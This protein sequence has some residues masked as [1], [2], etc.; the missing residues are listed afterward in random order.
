MSLLVSQ[1]ED[2]IKQVSRFRT[3]CIRIEEQFSKDVLLVTDVELVYSSSFLSACCQWEALLEATLFEA[4]CGEESHR[5]GNTR[6][7]TFRRRKYLQNVLLFQGKEYISIPSLKRAED[8]A[9]LFVT[10]G[11]PFSAVEATNRTFIQQA[12]WIRNAIA[13]QSA[14]ALRVFREKVPGVASL[15]SSKRHPGA[16]LRHEFRVSP[17]QRRYELYFGALQSAANQIAKS[18]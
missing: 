11:R 16:F 12:T 4:V 6:L 9:S 15:P 2:F 8:L 5:R 13:H 1:A 18:W 17:D 7:A 3:C 14:F 10:Q